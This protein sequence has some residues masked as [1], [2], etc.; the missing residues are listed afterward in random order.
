MPGVFTHTYPADPAGAEGLD[1]LLL[2][3]WTEY[4]NERVIETGGIPQTGEPIDSWGLEEQ[5]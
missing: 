3:G 1:Y 5:Q 4:G 2:T